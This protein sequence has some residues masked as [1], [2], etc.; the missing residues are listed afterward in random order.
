MIRD[1]YGA[2]VRLLICL[3]TS[4]V[5]QNLESEYP[6]LYRRELKNEIA[7]GDMVVIPLCAYYK[8]AILNAE[9]D[10]GLHGEVLNILMDAT[11]DICVDYGI[12]DIKYAD[13]FPQEW[14]RVFE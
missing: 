14:R 9:D 11:Q 4:K 7:F 2:H 12:T 5:V 8:V 13:D 1:V 3:S 10:A 6:E